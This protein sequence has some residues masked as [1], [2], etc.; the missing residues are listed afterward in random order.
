MVVPV[1]SNLHGEGDGAGFQKVFKANLWLNAGLA[2]AL[3]VSIAVFAGPIMAMYGSSFGGGR[4]VLIVLACS[5]FAEVL[6]A[7]LGQPLIASHQMW[8]RFAFDLLLV[9]FLVGVAWV[10]VPKWG[11]RGLAASY[12]VAYALTSLGLFLFQQQG[13]WNSSP[14]Y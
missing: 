9:I 4:I 1:L 5:A 3:A 7:I 2:L 13:L 8:R 14:S 11:A 10:L 6:N 12:V